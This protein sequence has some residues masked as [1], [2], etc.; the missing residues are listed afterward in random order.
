MVILILIYTGLILVGSLIGYFKAG[1]CP[2]LI[3]GVI[4]T[5]SLALFTFLYHRGIKGAGYGLLFIVL[6]LD[7]FF[8]WRFIKTVALVPSGLLSI[9]S[10]ILLIIMALHIK[11]KRKPL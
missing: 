5:I 3:A 7:S 11:K 8:T 1:S 4:S 2:S 6:A 9:I 10:T